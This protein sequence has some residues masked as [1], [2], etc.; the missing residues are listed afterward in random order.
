M[1][2]AVKGRDCI[3]G[4]AYCHE[5]INPIPSSG[6]DIEDSLDAFINAPYSGNGFSPEAERD[7]Q[8]RKLH[9]MQKKINTKDNLD[10][11]DFRDINDINSQK[12]K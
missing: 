6:S 4:G 7:Y 2:L 1:E 11:D 9:N 5:P 3:S 8:Q 12:K 10:R